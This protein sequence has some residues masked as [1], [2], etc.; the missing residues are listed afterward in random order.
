MKRLHERRDVIM[1]WLQMGL[2]LVLAPLFLFPAEKYVWVLLLFPCFLIFK[3]ILSGRVIERTVID[4]AI[5]L[6]L[7]QVLVTCFIVPDLWFS[8][9]KIAGVIFG[10]VFFYTALNLLKSELLIKWGVV[11]FLMLGLALA[12]AGVVGMRAISKHDIYFDKP[13]QKVIKFIPEVNWNLPG[14]EKGFNPNP[15]AGTLIL[16]IPVVLG[17]LIS[18]LKRKNNGCLVRRWKIPALIGLVIGLFVM[19]GVLFVTRSVASW[20]ALCLSA[21]L[22]FVSWRWK[23]W[24]LAAFVV[25]IGF[26]V[27][28]K[29]SGV[30]IVGKD[31]VKTVTE[32]KIGKR[33]NLWMA[34]IK[35]IKEHPFSGVGMNRMRQIPPVTYEH[36]HVHNH[37]I[38]TAAE[39]GIPGLVA[40]LAILMGMG[41]MCWEVARKAGR[42][43]TRGEQKEQREW[44]EEMEQGE[45]REQSEQMEQN[46]QSEQGE[47]EIEEMS[48]G[49]TGEER[50]RDDAGWLRAAVVGLGAGQLAHFIFGMGDSIPLGAK[51]GIFFW[52]SLALIAAMFNCIKRHELDSTD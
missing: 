22:I 43:R 34:G 15:L 6:L 9:P 18:C 51:P 25:F 40:Y 30:L 16:V 8:L 12:G 14:A 24:S 35:S 48:K 45:E 36:S 26:V 47:R 33:E 13:A 21:W 10:V 50:R 2:L 27:L 17:F 39:L 3:W 31:V 37:L 38:H 1:G 19:A 28:F 7:I 4:W 46:E 41:W 44:S 20:I 23:K 52:V 29:P 11:A 49:K 32:I 5:A 42:Q